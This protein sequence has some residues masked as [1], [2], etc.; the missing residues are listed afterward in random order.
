MPGNSFGHQVPDLLWY[1]W[2][3]ADSHKQS[4]CSGIVPSGVGSC[5]SFLS[6]ILSALPLHLILLSRPVGLACLYQQ[7]VHE[8]LIAIYEPIIMR[9]LLSGSLSW[10]G[11][12]LFSPFPSIGLAFTLPFPLGLTSCPPCLSCPPR[13]LLLL[14]VLSLSSESSPGPGPPRA[15]A[16]PLASDRLRALVLQ[17]L[18]AWSSVG[19]KLPSTYYKGF[20][21][22]VN[23]FRIF[24]TKV[25]I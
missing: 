5:L 3:I 2:L 13:L 21:E 17:V 7:S 25:R 14:R 24:G 19:N 10:A 1:H 20:F 22:V 4:K 16:F 9:L 15:A 12:M 6:W 18:R 23:H 11:P 8:V